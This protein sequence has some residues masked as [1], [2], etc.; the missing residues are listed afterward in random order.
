LEQSWRRAA[1]KVLNIPISRRRWNDSTHL[2]ENRPESE[3]IAQLRDSARNIVSDT[4]SYNDVFNQLQVAL[5]E[6]IKGQEDAYKEAA[7]VKKNKADFLAKRNPLSDEYLK[8]ANAPTTFTDLDTYLYKLPGLMG[9]SM[10]A[11]GWQMLSTGSGIAS[12]M[13]MTAGVATLD[14]A[15]IVAGAAMAGVNLTGQI[16]SREHES[17]VEVSEKYKSNI[18]AKLDPETYY[19]ILQDAKKQSTDPNETEDEMFDKLL[20][21]EYVTNDSKFVRLAWNELPGL[22]DVYKRNMS[23]SAVDVV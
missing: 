7:Q 11:F 3:I 17:L 18:K 8:K 20:S 1:D 21:G 19:R 4:Q 9:S 15:L 10:G 2:L 22:A 23:L 16:Q 14:P 5:D 12:G 6:S 13:L